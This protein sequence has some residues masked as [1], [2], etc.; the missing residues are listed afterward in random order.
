MAYLTVLKKVRVVM[1]VHK[2]TSG[3][4]WMDSF[5]TMHFLCIRKKNHYSLSI[6]SQT[7]NKAFK[8]CNVYISLS[9]SQ[10][11]AMQ[12]RQNCTDT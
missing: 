12:N 8:K 5:I 4:T 10:T 1:G 2:M 9:V 3:G 11:C 7:E 6:I